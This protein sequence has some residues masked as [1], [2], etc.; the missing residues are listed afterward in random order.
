MKEIKHRSG[1]PVSYTLDFFG[2]KWS[3]L[4][5]RDMMLFGK[6]TYGEFQSSAEKIA[7]NILAD[8]LS[9]LEHYGFVNKQVGTDKKSKFSYTLTEKG[10]SLVPVILEI[11][12]WGAQFHPPGLNP[13]LKAALQNDRQDTIQAIQEK[14]RS[15]LQP[16]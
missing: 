6:T 4:I 5:L 14:L 13:E 9:M 10:I 8:R 1:C 15:K 7:T 12:L 16:G 2:D 11:G 3:L